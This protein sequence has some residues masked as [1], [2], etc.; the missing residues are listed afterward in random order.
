MGGISEWSHQNRFNAFNTMKILKHV[1]YWESIK[2]TILNDSGDEIP[3]PIAVT[4]DLSLVCN[5]KCYFCNAK[6]VIDNKSFMSPKWMVALPRVL[7]KWGVRSVTIAGG[8]E[9]LTNPEASIFFYACKDV[10]LELGLITNGYY[11]DKFKWAII[12]CCDWVGVSVDAS[13]GET[14]KEIKGVD[15]YEKIIDNISMITGKGVEVTYKYLLCPKNIKDIINAVK[16]AKALYCNQIHIRPVG[17]AWFDNKK[18]IFT[19]DDINEA[20]NAVDTA[21]NL[22]EDDKFKVFGITHKFG[23]NW[24]IINDF[25]RC[26]STFMYLV[27]QPNGTLLTCCDRRGDDNVTLAKGLKEPRQIPLQW[28]VDNLKYIFEN[29]DVKKCCRCTFSIHNQVFENMILEDKTFSNFI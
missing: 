22:F 25:K 24:G 14:Y 15:Y 29:I 27:I 23:N 9:P 13:T 2:H 16:T 28:T 6:N 18:S 12:D 1:N 20:L 8:G 10:G 21:R 26:W 19:D 3:P 17:T 4:V 7:K 5:L 11:I